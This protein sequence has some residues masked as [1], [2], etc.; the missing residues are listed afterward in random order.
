MDRFILFKKKL[1][2]LFECKILRIEN[3]N[4]IKWRLR[5]SV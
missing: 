4:Y 2:L 5:I 1:F 3:R